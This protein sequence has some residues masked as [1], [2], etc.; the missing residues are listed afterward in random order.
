[1]RSPWCLLLVVAGCRL[2]TVPATPLAGPS[3]R[4][5]VI[6]PLANRG[7]A[8]GVD[9]L[10]AGVEQAMRARGYRVLPLGVGHD[11]IAQQELLP[12]VHLEAPGLRRVKDALD[13]EAVLLVEV[14][15]FDAEPQ[16]FDAASWDLQ[17][18]LLSTTTGGVLWQHREQGT[19]HRPLGEPIDPTRAP[20]AEQPVL[21]FGQA[22]PPVFRSVADLAMSLHRTAA[23][24]L[25][26]HQP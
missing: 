23:A 2:G 11:L 16:P 22:A 5:L 15:A 8:A 9:G 21:P 4:S 6:A 24:R 12:V 14:F 25:P 19:W 18:R 20:G 3:P 13:V 17:W 1:M 7:V 26:R 10:L